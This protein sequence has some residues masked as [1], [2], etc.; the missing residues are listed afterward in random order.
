MVQK[1]LLT[2]KISSVQLRLSCWNRVP[3]GTTGKFAMWAC[4]GSTYVRHA[5]IQKKPHLSRGCSD[6]SPSCLYLLPVG[7]LV[8]PAE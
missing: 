4:K 8:P 1:R 6:L 2:V 7:Y 3:K 5:G